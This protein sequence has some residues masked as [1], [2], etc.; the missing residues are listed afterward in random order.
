MSV[1]AADCDNAVRLLLAD[2]RWYSRRYVMRVIPG[3]FDLRHACIERLLDQDEIA[4]D[5]DAFG[6]EWLHAK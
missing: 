6:Q 4:E 5:Y 3:S 2:G 1:T